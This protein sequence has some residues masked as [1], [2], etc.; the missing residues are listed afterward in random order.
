MT[1]GCW[2]SSRCGTLRGR[3]RGWPLCNT[4]S[5]RTIPFGLRRT[6]RSARG[7]PTNLLLEQVLKCGARLIERPGLAF[8]ARRRGL[9]VRL[10]VVAEVG[11]LAVRN[12]FGLRLATAV[13][14]RRVVVHTV[15]DRK[16]VV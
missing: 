11:A 10:E 4:H 13:V 16:S 8:R 6:R 12:P 15:Q 9:R 7:K 3:R 5:D 14:R 1:H 2:G